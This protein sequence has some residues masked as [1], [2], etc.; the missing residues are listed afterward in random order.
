ME[1]KKVAFARQVKEE[2]ATAFYTKEEK[3]YILSGFIRN[4]ALF[5]LGRFPSLSLKTESAQIAKLIY[6]G[7]K[8]AFALSPS[9]GYENETRFGRGRVYVLTVR[10]EPRL[11]EVMKDLEILDDSGLVRLSPSL[12]LKRKNLRFF[13]IGCFLANGSV[14]NPSSLKTSYFLEMAFTQKSDAMETKKKLN[15]FKA[16]RTMSFKYIKRR[17]KDVLYLKKSDQISVF[18]SYLGAT[19]CMFTYENARIEK[20]QI[21]TENRLSICDSANYSRAL[22]TASKDIDAIQLV[23]T[24]KPLSLFDE[25]TRAVIEERLANKDVSYRELS[26]LVTAK[27]QIPITKSGVVHIIQGLR[28]QAKTLQEES[29]SSAVSERKI[30]K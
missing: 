5:T 4:G 14:N 22:K 15:S 7:L 29:A 6:S 3:K 27:D 10:G 30:T 9:L 2:L 28:N 8:E 21:N 16:E 20:D 23:L 1:E 24:V 26:D 19:Q 12:S 17:D 13:V 18:L 25:K 11:Y